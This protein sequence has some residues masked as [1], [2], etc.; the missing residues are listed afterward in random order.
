MWDTFRQ[1][2]TPKTAKAERRR[3]AKSPTRNA[4]LQKVSRNSPRVRGRSSKRARRIILF[5]SAENTSEE[6]A[7]SWGVRIGRLRHRVP[8]RIAW[9]LRGW[10]L[11]PKLAQADRSLRNPRS[12]ESST[13]GRVSEKGTP[14][15][16][17][18]GDHRTSFRGSE[19]TLF[20][21]RRI[22]RQPRALRRH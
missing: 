7:V 17:A 10:V 8:V 14:I 13:T 16:G 5:A 22:R 20:R 11:S 9:L 3:K 15:N 19:I 4:I 21:D 1:S 18:F 2:R 6:K 12:S